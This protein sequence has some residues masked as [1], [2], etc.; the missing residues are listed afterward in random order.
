MDGATEAVAFN[1]G[2]LTEVELSSTAYET[3]LSESAQ[4]I[5]RAADTESYIDNFKVSSSDIPYV[6]PEQPEQ[7][8]EKLTEASLDFESD[9]GGVFTAHSDGGWQVVDGKYSPAAASAITKSVNKIDVTGT[10]YLSFDFYAASAPFDFVLLSDINTQFTAETLGGWVLD[11]SAYKPAEVGSMAYLTKKI[12]LT[13]AEGITLSLDFSVE[14]E[15]DTL[16]S[17]GFRVT[18]GANSASGISLH[19]YQTPSGTQQLRINYSFGNHEQNVDVEETYTAKGF[20]DGKTHGLKLIVKNSCLF[21]LIDGT[22][23]FKDYAVNAQAGYFTV[24]SNETGARLSNL[25][26]TG[27]AE[28][29]TEPDAS[30]DESTELTPPAK[31]EPTV[32]LPAEQTTTFNEVF[33]ILA[34]VFGGLTVIGA[35]AVVMIVIKNKKIKKGEENDENKE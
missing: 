29:L 14:G 28:S 17:L 34:S 15:A 21:V 9:D 3:A 25:Q 32:A 16:F 8:E 18:K 10:V 23:I 30:K 24:K 11:G 22:V 26:L 1:G 31:E 4:V 35:V 13:T 12:P 5:F 6:A 27:K 19:F 20:M 2:A 33:V 7:P